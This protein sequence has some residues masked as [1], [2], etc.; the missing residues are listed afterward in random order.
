MNPELFIPHPEQAEDQPTATEMLQRLLKAVRHNDPERI[1]RVRQQYER[2]FPEQLEGVAII[3]QFADYLDADERL[4]TEDDDDERTRLIRTETEYHFL[5]TH[6]LTQSGIDRSFLASLWTTLED[7]AEAR[8]QAKTIDGMRRGML[9]QAA[10]YKI[11]EQLG[12]HPQL[13][14]PAE[15]AEAIDL[16]EEGNPVQVKGS[17]KATQPQ[18]IPTETVAD[19]P[20]V[21]EDAESMRVFSSKL[22]HD[23]R[24]FRRKVASINRQT[25]KSIS[26]YFIVIPESSYDS[27]SGVPTDEIVRFVSEKLGLRR[28]EEI[29]EAA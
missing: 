16:W 7:L 5:L 3:T 24:R 15:D 25:R 29:A 18:I 6:Y 1:N 22:L 27:V 19:P 20:I 14:H 21:V 26:G 28:K 4:T 11:F 17:R 12:A 13:S 10:T 2:A 23:F 9:S 8:G